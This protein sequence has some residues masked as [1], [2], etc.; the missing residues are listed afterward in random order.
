METM[1]EDVQEMTML[2]G[3]NGDIGHQDGK[4]MISCAKSVGVIMYIIPRQLY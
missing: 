2:S 1:E 3:I 4:L